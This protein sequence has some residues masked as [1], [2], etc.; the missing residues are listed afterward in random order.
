[1]KTTFAA[2]PESLAPFFALLV[3]KIRGGSQDAIHE[4]HLHFQRG[5]TYVMTRQLGKDRAGELVQDVLE[6]VLA[7]IR[8]GEVRQAESL[9]AF[10]QSVMHRTV[11]SEMRPVI[12]RTGFNP[13]WGADLDSAERVLRSLPSRDRE[14]LVRFYCQEQPVTKICRELGVT[15]REFRAIKSRA[16]DQFADSSANQKKI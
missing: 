5:I 14:I 16:K 12:P 4:L 7:G 2:E 15:A 9:P 13:I 11:A 6:E 8:N 1:L 3:E 10:V